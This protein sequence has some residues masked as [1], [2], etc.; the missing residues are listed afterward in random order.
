M[1]VGILN[2]ATPA[3]IARIFCESIKGSGLEV[4]MRVQVAKAKPI[5]WLATRQKMTRPLKGETEI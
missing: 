3:K 5:R 2:I 1:A 4:G